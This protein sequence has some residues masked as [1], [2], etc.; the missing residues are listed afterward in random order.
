MVI[1]L[2]YT[3]T[4]RWTHTHPPKTMPMILITRF[5]SKKHTNGVCWRISC[6]FYGYLMRVLLGHCTGIWLVK[7]FV[8]KQVLDHYVLQMCLFPY[9]S[10]Q[11]LWAGNLVSITMNYL[12]RLEFDHYDETGPIIFRSMASSS[13]T[14]F[15]GLQWY[16]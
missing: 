10:Q 1:A 14:A 9:L 15:C 12:K 16:W 13:Q 11:I 4:S 6:C 2:Y 5:G 8:T 7:F 3:L